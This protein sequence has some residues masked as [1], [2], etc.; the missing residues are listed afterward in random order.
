MNTTIMSR[1]NHPT[2]VQGFTLVELM[3]AVA[4]VGILAAVAIPQYNSHITRSR[5]PEATNMLASRAVMAEQFF[6][7]NRTYET[8]ALVTNPACT[9]NT[10]NAY[11]DF[12]CSA[13][14][15]N[16][17]TIQAVGKG[18]MAGFTYTINQAGGRA[19]TAVPTGWTASTT[20]W[21]IKKDGSC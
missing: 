13:A 19:T 8:T 20:C 14:T 3:V 1:Q 6:Q 18:N 9:S 15:A 12:S 21:V 10:S 2:T 16:T 11:F 7:D 5:I 17:F 4:I